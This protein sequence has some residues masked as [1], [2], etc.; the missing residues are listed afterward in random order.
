MRVALVALLALGACSEPAA[1]ILPRTESAARADQISPDG[2][3]AI[4][5]GVS[6]A[7]ARANLGAALSQMEAA[8]NPESCA[9]AAYTTDDGQQLLL[10]FE[11][12][13]VTSLY[14]GGA[15]PSVRTP[16][17]LGVGS[18]AAEVRAAYPAALEEPAKY[19]DPPAHNLIIWR[20]PNESGLRFEIGSDGK[21][22]AIH[23]G[24]PSI[25]YVEGCA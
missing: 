25:L 7:E 18:T 14:A 15:A 22:T 6:L 8:D 17:G 5:I 13:R 20:A 23:A 24:G 12:S 3:G 11:R 19:D 2:F 10:M 21:V 1:P 16:E 9:T 4:H